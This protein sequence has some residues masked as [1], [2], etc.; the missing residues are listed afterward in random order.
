[1]FDVTSNTL[2]IQIL[3]S[4]CAWGD[5]EYINHPKYCHQY[6]LEETSNTLIIQ[7]LSSICAWDDVEYINHPNTVINVCLSWN[8]ILYSSKYC[9][10][11]VFELASNTFLIQILSSICA[12]G[13]VKYINHP[14]TVI[15]V[16]L[17]WRRI[18]YSSK[19]CHQRV[20]EL[21]S[22]TLIIQI[23]SSMCAWGDIKC[24]NL[25]NTVINGCLK[26]RPI[27]YSSKYCHQ[28]VLE[29]TSNTLIIQ[30]LSSICAWGDVVYINHPNSVINVCLRWRRIH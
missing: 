21:A 14:N 30:I 11:C 8:R 9:H 17:S 27:H 18:H 23:L 10:Q 19:Y 2:I 12:W 24:I 6:L 15:N 4:I 3:S 28:C 25:P 20:L 29:V 16:C 7:I 1:V 5:V 22:N 26:W 13:D